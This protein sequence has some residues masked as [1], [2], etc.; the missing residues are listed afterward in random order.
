MQGLA[1]EKVWVERPEAALEGP[2]ELGQQVWTP[3]A[4]EPGVQEGEG[5]LWR[6]QACVSD[7]DPGL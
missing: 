2:W 1:L 4:G 5:D 7:D 3:R 6:C